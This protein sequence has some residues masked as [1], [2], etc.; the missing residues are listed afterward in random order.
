MKHRTCNLLTAVSIC[1][2][3]PAL[4]YAQTGAD[5]MKA[6]KK[7]DCVVAFDVN[8]PGKEYKVNWGMD[9]AWDWDFNVNR[10]IAHI[11]KDN[12]STGRVS[13]QPY[14]L[15]TDN[16]DG[17][18][19]LT[20]G[21]KK[22]LKWRCDLIAATGTKQVNIN[23]DHE[24]LFYKVDANG[25]YPESNGAK[26]TDYTG[27]T[28]YRG[29]PQEWYKLIKASVAYVKSLGLEVVSI[30]PFNEPDYVWE[31]AT[32]ENQAMVDFLAIAQLLKADSY[33]DGIRICG[34]NTLNCDRALPWYNYLAS[35]IDEGNTHQLA[36]SFD[37]YA[38]FFTQVR[39]DGKQATADELH[40]VGEAIVGVN[41]GMQNGIWW[42][43]DSKARG[44]FCIDSN[45]GVRLGY[46]EN[47]KAWTNAAVYRN[48]KTG[49]V[50]GYF[51]SSER[52][53]AAS[54]YQYLSTTKDVFFNG[55]GPTRSFVYNVPAYQ[56]TYQYG[57]I[58][59]ERLFDITW[60]EDVAPGEVNGT[61]RILNAYSKKMVT[62]NGSNNIQS[63]SYTSR[64]TTQHW[65]VTP[66]YV[67]FAGE[68]KKDADGNNYISYGEG[69]SGDVSYWF[70]DNA[71][72]TTS[73][74]NVLNNNL[75]AGA[76]VICYNA[77]H[78]LNEQWYLKYAKD[79]YYFIISRLSN[80]YL[81]CSAITSGTNISLMDA[82][83]EN[84][85]ESNL[86]KYLWRFQ[87]T[88]SKAD[89]NVPE[90]PT[91]IGARQRPG[92]I[93]LTWTAPTDND[94]LTY[95]VLRKEDGEWNTI[96]RNISGTVFTDNTVV[97]GK[98]YS[99]KLKAV[100]LAGNRS[101]DSEEIS[102]A[103]LQ[104]KALLCQ[105]QF[106]KDLSDQSA[107]SM[108]A[109]LYGKEA[110]AP[111]ASYIKSGTSALNMISQDSYVQIPYSL[112]H[113]PSMTISAWVRWSGGDAWQRI[114][115]F[116]NG[117][118]SYMF[119][120]PSN[121]SNM[122]FVMKNGGSEEVIEANKLAT[123]TYK[124]IAVTIE[125]TDE[126]TTAV[127]LYVNGEAVATKSDFTINPADIAASVAYIGRSQFPSDP[128]YKGYVDDFRIYNYAL[129]AEEIAA[130]MEDLGETS[131]DI[132]DSYV[133]I[134]PSGISTPQANTD[135][136][137][138]PVYN[139]AGQQVQA[140]YRGI[141]IQNN[142]KYLNK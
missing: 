20:A 83:A 45:E 57:Q 35:S 4:S 100:D 1:C 19:E 10:G 18:Y 65:K 107:N 132:K 131:N 9:A 47:R 43:F 29:K 44:Q 84:I 126:G 91:N 69:V 3:F 50:H 99:Y 136:S 124:H 121:G 39:S 105:L 104:E 24:A 28:N 118:N 34:G 75:N 33:F 61:Y 21:Q 123:T 68:V 72:I 37:N 112:T 117:E 138:S 96:G 74:W 103:P 54:S 71:S 58:N 77:G 78:G 97:A 133:D 49:E 64:G 113:L 16:G 32:S 8:A 7:A 73:H 129:S 2:M 67:D 108:N 13:F 76:G 95:T 56:G 22:K 12:F 120:T 26:I 51:G 36:G 6:M 125:P 11:G 127:T 53:A 85:S 81:Y 87:P 70:I 139:T 79:G 93:Q 110:Y 30:S 114:F 98:Q 41:Y 38:N 17:T 142:K 66:V 80:K 140:D 94:P 109:S 14:D 40:N 135:G 46:G 119:L 134:L 116:G 82:P 141:I 42:G 55:Y 122:R 23:C 48:E 128:L 88:D 15:V 59:A 90:V 62:M 86:K 27:R 52:Q 5:Y 137:L 89:T 115:D 63:A 60:G 111:L 106:D 130:V 25:N 31:Q 92:S 102:A 101:A